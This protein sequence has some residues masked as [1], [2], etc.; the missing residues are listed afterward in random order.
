MISGTLPQLTCR[1]G[2]NLDP[3]SDHTCAGTLPPPAA[4][5]ERAAF[6]EEVCPSASRAGDSEAQFDSLHE[7]QHALL[8]GLVPSLQLRFLS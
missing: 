5:I 3:A 4:M 2:V 7:I 1:K 6:R 8:L